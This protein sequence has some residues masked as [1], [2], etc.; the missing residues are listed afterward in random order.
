M[1]AAYLNEHKQ[2]IEELALKLTPGDIA[3]LVDELAQKDDALRYAA[4]SA[5]QKRSEQ[6]PDVYPHWDRFAKRLDDE[7]SYQR[8]VGIMLIAE[9]VKWDKEGRFR[10]VFGSYMRHC[11]DER[12]I[13]SRQTIQGVARWAKHAPELLEEAIA[14][15]INIDVNTLKDTQKKLILI[16]ILSALAAMR[17]VHPSGEI[18]EYVRR[19]VTGGIL[20]K[21]AVRQLESLL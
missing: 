12:F 4:F 10:Q 7:N 13:T 17:K 3:A 14:I 6:T 8:S 2:N 21:K 5:L 19:A 16:D 15:L 18:E 11:S 20:D 1:D 9:N